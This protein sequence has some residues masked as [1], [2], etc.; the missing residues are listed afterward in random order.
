MNFISRRK[1]QANAEYNGW[2]LISST[3][4]VDKYIDAGQTRALTTFW[5]RDGS[6]DKFA[7]VDSIGPNSNGPGSSR[8]IRTTSFGVIDE[9]AS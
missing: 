4:S 2:E 3:Y 8:L 6:Q 7:R 1:V 5:H 9:L